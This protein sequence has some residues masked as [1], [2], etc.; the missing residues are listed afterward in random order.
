MNRLH[1]TFNFARTLET[2]DVRVDSAGVM[3]DPPAV[4][5]FDQLVAWIEAR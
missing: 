5:V 1:G 4:M 3:I 2:G